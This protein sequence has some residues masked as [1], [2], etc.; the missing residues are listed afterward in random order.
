VSESAT[1]KNI[2]ERQEQLL[3]SAAPAMYLAL[4]RVFNDLKP[5][6][7]SDAWLVPAAARTV[8]LDALKLARRGAP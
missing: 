7:G 6:D 5:V 8:L 3:Q 4:L 2:R 1:D